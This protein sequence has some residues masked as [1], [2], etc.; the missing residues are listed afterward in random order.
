VRINCIEAI[1]PMQHDLVATPI[2]PVDGWMQPL[3][4][5]GLGIEV[6]EDVVDHY[7]LDRGA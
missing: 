2:E 6:L 3:C 1:P 7:R 5:P 4:G